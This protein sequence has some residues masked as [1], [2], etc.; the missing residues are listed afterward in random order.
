MGEL[1]LSGLQMLS[2]FPD[3]S[4]GSRFLLIVVSYFPGVVFHMN[5]DGSLP[6]HMIYKI[7]QNASLTMNTK[8]VRNRFWFP[9]PRVWGYNYYYFGFV[10]VQVSDLFKKLMECGC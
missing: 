6:N 9:G 5:N 4:V 8:R 2:C 1:E 10:W 3:A 7:R